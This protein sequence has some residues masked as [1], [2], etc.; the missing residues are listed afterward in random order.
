MA[1]SQ[2]L[3]VTSHEIRTP[4]NGILGAAELLIATPLTP[5]QQR[6]V[7]TAH[8]SATALLALIDDVLDL[9]RI[10]AGQLSLNPSET[11]LRALVAEAVELVAVTARDKPIELS[12]EVAPRVPARVLA[13]ALRLR[14]LLL[15]LLHNAVK[16]SESGPVSL[17]VTVLEETP[18]TLQLRL[19]VRD[20]GIGI[21]ADQLDSI[22]GAFTQVDSSSTR[23]H[24]GSGLGLAIV[25]Q[26]TDL[27]GGPVRVRSRLGE[28]SEFT[29]VLPLQKAV[30][31]VAAEAELWPMNDGPPVRVGGRGRPRQ[32][33][34]DRGDAQ[35]P[36]LR[37]AG[38]RRRRG[39]R[40]R[41]AASN[42]TWC[43]WTATCR[44]STATKLR[45]ASDR[46][47]IRT[48]RASRSSR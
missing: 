13:D 47:S 14:Q 3:A 46:T 28:G 7:R 32:P 2:F 33:D 29:V 48:A 20:T 12:C 18:Q 11:D 8:R 40:G 26:L 45:A 16:F 27:M 23:R 38:C 43:S 42:S 19:S 17:K 24:G 34:G 41:G 25:K 31:A 37:S 9:S 6:Y 15:N 1:K 22:F 30:E 21:A 36:G 10:E 44:C 35:A 39:T 4:M 5:T